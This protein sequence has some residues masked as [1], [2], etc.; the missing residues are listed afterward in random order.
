MKSIQRAPKRG[1][2]QLRCICRGVAEVVL[3]HSIEVK[4]TGNVVRQRAT[5]ESEAPVPQSPVPSRL[6]PPPS[7]S[8]DFGLAASGHRL[9][10]GHRDDEGRGDRVGLRR[11]DATKL[12]HENLGELGLLELRDLRLGERVDHGLPLPRERGGVQV[13]ASEIGCIRGAEVGRRARDGGEKKVGLTQWQCVHVAHLT[14]SEGG[15]GGHQPCG[16]SGGGEGDCHDAVR[17]EVDRVL[18]VVTS[19]RRKV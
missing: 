2:A 6:G 12:A 18:R 9:E 8:G 15:Q 16:A 11:D 17:V 10:I 19:V 14:P 13:L 4:M 1:D 3:E 5:A 7:H